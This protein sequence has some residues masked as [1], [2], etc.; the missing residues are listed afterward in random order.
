MPRVVGDAL[1]WCGNKHI[2]L[3][4]FSSIAELQYTKYSHKTLLTVGLPL[5]AVF[6][7]CATV[8]KDSTSSCQLLTT[9]KRQRDNC[10]CRDTFLSRWSKELVLPPL[11]TFNTNPYS[12]Y[13][14]SHPYIPVLRVL[15]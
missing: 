13:N 1:H 8:P 5:K 11:F 12:P 14:T 7:G 6:L 15:M 3:A 4:L 9:S 10:C 2:L